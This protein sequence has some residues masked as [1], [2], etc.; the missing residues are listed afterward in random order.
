MTPDGI[1][2]EW[3]SEVLGDDVEL[4]GTTRI[5]DGLVG[6]NLRLELRRS[7]HS[8]VPATLIA[9]LPTLD[10]TS[11]GTAKALRTYEREVKF[12]EQI[13]TTVDV[14]VAHCH[15][16]EW[17]ESN[18]DFALLLEDLAPAQPGNQLTGCSAQQSRAAVLELARLHGPR[19]GDPTLD[20]IEF[21]QRRG[22]DD[23]AMLEGLWN[24]LLPGFLG[25]YAK[26]L[27]SEGIG[28]IERF[29][30]RLIDWIAGHTMPATVTHG[31][32]RLD[33]LMFRSALGGYPIA[34]VDWQT[35]GHGAASGDVSY[36]LGAGPLPDLRREIERELVED[37]CG[38]LDEYGVTV[39]HDE[40]WRHFRRDAYSGIIMSVIASQIVGESERSEA[41]FAAMA[42]RHT[43]HALDLAAESLI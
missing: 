40:F 17:T 24:M 15:Y 42:T 2:S 36:F 25:T 23:A 19:W 26:Y 30:P 34:A 37:Y 31:D 14:R 12:Y 20:E 10:P 3:L 35:P 5:G 43:R 7:Q 1:T 8:A 29:G 27:D 39:D 41:M 18:D 11:R 16:A 32:Y 9:K 13:A 6:M 38:A 21:L 28:L 33:N 4:V 22:A